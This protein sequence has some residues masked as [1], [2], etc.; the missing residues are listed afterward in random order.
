MGWQGM[1]LAAYCRLLP[2]GLRYGEAAIG[3]VVTAPACRGQQLGHTLLQ[4]AMDQSCRLYPGKGISLSA[5]SHL[6][7][8]Y[9]RHGFKVEGE[10]YIEDGIPHLHMVRGGGEPPSE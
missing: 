2:P 10:G 9:E 1:Q 3:R 5:Q 8:F 7:L 4:R 6:R